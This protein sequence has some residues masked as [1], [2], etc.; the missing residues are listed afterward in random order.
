MKCLLCSGEMEKRNVPYAIDR[1]GYHLYIR[2]IPASVCSQCGEQYFDEQEVEEIQ[3][4]I[5]TLEQHIEK[6]KAA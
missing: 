6:L 2:E 5:E 1:G 3:V 4:I